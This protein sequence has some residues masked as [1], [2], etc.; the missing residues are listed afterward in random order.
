MWRFA[1]IQK[2]Q[3]SMIDRKLFNSKI[4]FALFFL[5]FLISSFS[6]SCNSAKESFCGL[7]RWGWLNTN[8]LVVSS[9]KEEYEY[10]REVCPQWQLLGQSLLIDNSKPY[11]FL[12]FK[13]PDG[14][15]RCLYF[16][17][18]KFFGKDWTMLQCHQITASYITMVKTAQNFETSILINLA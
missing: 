1:I 14:Q 11:D 13:R 7:Q 17:V 9:I 3:V 4:N 16:D 2:P 12:E 15:K 8:V 5:G 10:V 6:I 18:S